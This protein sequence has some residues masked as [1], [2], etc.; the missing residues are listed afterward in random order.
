MTIEERQNAAENWAS[1]FDNW[2]RADEIAHDADEKRIAARKVLDAAFTQL[3]LR[4]MLSYNVPTRVFLL[5]S[6]NS[7]YREI[8]KV[9]YTRS[10]GDVVAEL[11]KTEPNE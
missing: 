2:R 3:K 8:V 10:S 7:N 11:L 5:P 9:T 6:T 1:A 4:S